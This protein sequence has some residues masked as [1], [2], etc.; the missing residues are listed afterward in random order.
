MSSLCR[1]RSITLHAVSEWYMDVKSNIAT[2]LCGG[3]V[4]G[5]LESRASGDES[6]AGNGGRD[7]V[8]SAG[9]GV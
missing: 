2:S 4:S 7:S 9:S 6:S 3:L 8:G 1:L 5:G